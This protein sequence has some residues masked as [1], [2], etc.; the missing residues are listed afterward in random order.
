MEE[1]GH[2]R[3][4][5]VINSKYAQSELERK[6]AQTYE[7]EGHGV[8]WLREVYETMGHI[9]SI[10][11]KVN[12]LTKSEGEEYADK[13]DRLITLLDLAALEKEALRVLKTVK[14]KRAKKRGAAIRH[15]ANGI[16]NQFFARV[17]RRACDALMFELEKK[18]WDD[19]LVL[20]AKAHPI[21]RWDY[22][23]GWPGEP[24]LDYPD[25]V[26]VIKIN[27]D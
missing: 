7:L 1:A 3:D 16:F 26:K 2:E 17:I 24:I 14:R 10:R 13:S 25:A 5:E 21:G 6:M 9:T 18:W 11:N 15:R 12:M 4:S 23:K 27:L 19:W 8:V 20:T 22:S